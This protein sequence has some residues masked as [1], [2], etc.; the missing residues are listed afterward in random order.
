ML[1]AHKT[2]IRNANPGSS[3]ARALSQHDSATRWAYNALLARLNEATQASPAGALWPSVDDLAKTLRREKPEW[4][5]TVDWEMLDNGWIRLATAL[6]RWGQCRK[7]KP[8]WHQSGSCGFPRFHRRGNRKSVSFSSHVGDGRRV[9]WHDQR[10]ITLPSIGTLTLAEPLSEVGWVKQVHA[11]RG[12]GRWYA[13]LVYENGGQL[14]DVP[15]DGPVVG[16]DVGI[17]V[18][19]F[20]SDG[21]EYH[22]PRWFRRGERKLR[23][24]NKA[25]ARSIKLNP[26]RRTNRRGRLY[27]QRA[28]LQ[29]QQANQRQTHQRQ[30]A[31]AIAKS[32]GTVVVE[33][34]NIA[35]MVRNRRLAKALTAAAVGGFLRELEWQCV[36]RGVCGC[37]K[38]GCGSPA[39]RFAPGAV[40]A[41]TQRIDLSVRLYRC[42]LC[43]WQCNRDRNAVLNLKQVA[44]ALWATIK[45]GGGDVS[46]APGPATA[47]EAS[48]G[49]GNH[50]QPPC[51]LV[52]GESMAGYSDYAKS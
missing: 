12:G 3:I 51:F 52:D 43:G 40:G 35:G 44:P 49:Q 7:G 48:I 24:I 8:D 21:E 2:R 5:A 32:A 26:N 46:P 45:G 17:K 1:R 47:S 23:R 4:W 15:G 37:S 11:V 41:P 39:L 19:A 13:V 50:W 20:T 9:Q 31:S 38:Q 33:T 30:T 10:H 16:V 27:G 34:L 6:Q 29:S 14:P 25:I 36:K 28:R 18:L 42:H 22:N